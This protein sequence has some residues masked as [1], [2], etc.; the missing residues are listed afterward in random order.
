M[1]ESLK[2]LNAHMVK[3]LETKKSEQTKL[4]CFGSLVILDA[5]CCY[6]LFFLLCINLEIGEIDVKY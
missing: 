4:F 5:V 2:Y 3:N 6:L 1:L